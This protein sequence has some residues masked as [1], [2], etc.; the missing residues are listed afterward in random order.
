MRVIEAKFEGKITELEKRMNQ[1][2]KKY[3]CDLT[4]EL[5]RKVNET[6]ADHVKT[7]DTA[8]NVK[9]I[10]KEVITKKKRKKKG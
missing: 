8:S 3:S 2:I 9:N 10:V 4:Q 5:P 6:W 7:S 1:K